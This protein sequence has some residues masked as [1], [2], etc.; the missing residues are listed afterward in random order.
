MKV[1]LFLSSLFIKNSSLF[2]RFKE[3][4][5]NKSFRYGGNDVTHKALCANFMMLKLILSLM[6]NQP[7]K[8]T[9]SELL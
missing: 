7:S 6:G 8:I 3:S 9:S 2:L 1:L 5:L 4:F